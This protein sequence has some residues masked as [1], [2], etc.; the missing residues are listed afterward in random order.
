VVRDAGVARVVIGV[1]DPIE[2]HSG[3]IVVLRR[4][5]IKV[6]VGVLA[7]ECA[8]ANRA[9]L[10]W[11]TSRRPAFTLKAAITLDGKIA[12]VAG[13]SK[14]I[15]GE[16]ARA[17]VMR[18]RDQHDAVLVGIGTVLADDPWLTARLVG[19]RDPIR[20]VI[21]SQ[22][23]TPPSAHVLPRTTGPR[24][25]LVCA[26]EAPAAREARLVAKGAE[27]WRIATHRNGRINFLP[28]ARRLADAG[29]VSVLAEGGGEIHAY[30]LERGLADELVIYLAPKV[31][32]GPAKS[33]VGGK[34]LATLASAYRFTFDSDPVD[35]AGDLRI[36]A[37]PVPPPAPRP[38]GADFDDD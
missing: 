17:D 38:F 3:G 28:L 22:L 2:D 34:G 4:A 11:A 16:L 10:T 7:D 13:R 18:L 25:I 9:F 31:V 14:W 24:T 29:I 12:T 5:R 1:E 26:P 21:D 6:T 27:V 33:W 8:R 15:T 23:R 19:G 20:I 32:G 30:L 35:L 36:T 37:V